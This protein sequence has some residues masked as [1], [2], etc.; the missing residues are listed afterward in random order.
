[1]ISY[2]S[3][4]IV[5][6]GDLVDNVLQRGRGLFRSG[7]SKSIAGPAACSRAEWGRPL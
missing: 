2:A 1:M 4:S 3:G 5:E 7:R 6:L